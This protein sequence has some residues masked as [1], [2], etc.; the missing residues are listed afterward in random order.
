MLK[1]Y[2]LFKYISIT[3]KGS[4]RLGQILLVILLFYFFCLLGVPLFVGRP[5][6]SVAPGQPHL[7]PS[8]YSLL[9]AFIAAMSCV[10][11]SNDDKRRRRVI[12]YG[13]SGT[14]IQTESYAQRRQP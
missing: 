9:L 8:N 13:L 10:L 14:D 3:T 11:E 12:E 7:G 6:Q 1:I 4:V 5:S 2:L